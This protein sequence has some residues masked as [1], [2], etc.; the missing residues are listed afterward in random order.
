MASHSG[1]PFNLMR[2]LVGRKEHDCALARFVC[3]LVG[4]R[5]HAGNKKEIKFFNKISKVYFST[6]RIASLRPITTV[7]AA[8]AAAAAAVAAAA[9][10]VVLSLKPASGG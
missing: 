8:A 10:A 2:L 7:V 3:A 1:P 5:C 6:K 9:A 4:R